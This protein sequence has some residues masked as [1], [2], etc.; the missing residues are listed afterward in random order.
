MIFR[1]LPKPGLVPVLA[2]F[3][4]P[5]AK[6]FEKIVHFNQK[7]AFLLRAFPPQN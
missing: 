2:K 1:A 6:F 3:S 7:F 4:A 5:Q